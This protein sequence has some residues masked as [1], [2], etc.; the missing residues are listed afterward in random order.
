MEERKTKSNSQEVSFLTRVAD[1][2]F[3]LPQY[4]LPHHALSRLVYRAT[5]VKVAW[6]KNG[7]IKYFIK[8]FKIDMQIAEK[9]DPTAYE[10]FNHFFTRPLKSGARP[11]ADG[12]EVLIS[13]VDAVVSQFGALVGD[14]K[15]YLI[16]AK[17]HNYSVDSLLGGRSP[18][19][20][21]FQGG[22]FATLYLSPSDYHRIHMPLEGRL[23]ETIYVPGR[24][25]SVNQATARSVPSLFARN[26][27]LVTIFE[28]DIGPM[29]L[30]MVGALCV[31]GIETVWDGGIPRPP[32][33]DVQR[34]TYEQSEAA[35]SFQKGD[36]IGRFNMGSTVILLFGSDQIQWA[37][38]VQLEE[39]IQMG[40][41]LAQKIVD[42]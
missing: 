10:S 18:W 36:E 8:I 29:A 19:S 22:Q 9:S 31:S 12:D 20:S 3:S 42:C 28:T 33:T 6:W 24:L 27:R 41:L 34:K 40:Q 11:I 30:I 17:G 26:E 39:K 16:Q 23:L 32:A 1:T 2:L 25:F 15:D 21:K 5:Q 13:P 37:G 35:I 4:L 7:F 38:S 14:G